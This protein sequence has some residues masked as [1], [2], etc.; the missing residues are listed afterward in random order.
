[1]AAVLFNLYACLV[2]ER[3][4]ARMEGAKG[5]GVHLH[6]KSDGKLFWRYL[7]NACESYLKGCQFSDDTALLATTR[8]E[9]KKAL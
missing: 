2:A 1:M 4:S 6:H 7:R 5:V 8:E 3:W 9:A